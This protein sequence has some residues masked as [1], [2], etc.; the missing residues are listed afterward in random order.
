MKINKIIFI[1]I[2]SLTAVVKIQTIIIII[3]SILKEN[4]NFNTIVLYKTGVNIANI[5]VS[6]MAIENNKY[7]GKI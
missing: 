3:T 2:Y 6:I 7:S 1:N 5:I 4:S